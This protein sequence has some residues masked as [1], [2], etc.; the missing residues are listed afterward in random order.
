MGKWSIALPHKMRY[1]LFPRAVNIMRI[2][3]FADESF[4]LI[5]KESN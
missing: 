1:A 2:I 3:Y 4:F 5:L